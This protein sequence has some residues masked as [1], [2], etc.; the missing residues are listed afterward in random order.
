[1]NKEEVTRFYDAF[2]PQQL[3]VSFNERH[4]LLF[5]ELKQLGLSSNSSVLELGCGIGVMTSLMAAVAQNGYIEAVDISPESIGEA[6]KRI[7]RQGMINFV[8]ADLKPFESNRREF[9]FITLMDVLEHIPEEDHDSIFGKISM[10]MHTDSVL[11]I[12]IP[13]PHLIAFDKLYFPQD[14]QIIDQELRADQLINRAYKAGLELDFFRT[15]GIWAANDYHLIA[16]RKKISYTAEKLS[17]KRNLLHKAIHR[18]CSWKE[19]ALRSGNYRL[20]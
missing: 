14:V 12:S 3:A 1:M 16:F 13:S 17:D 4:L 20:S 19:K 6:K 18:I 9:D 15:V 5:R 7:K 11:F 2:A 10:L 8:V